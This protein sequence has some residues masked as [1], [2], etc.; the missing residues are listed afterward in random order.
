MQMIIYHHIGKIVKAQ[1]QMI[2]II[3]MIITV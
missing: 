1:E 2:I 3:M